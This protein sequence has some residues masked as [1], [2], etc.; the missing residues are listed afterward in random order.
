[1]EI[2]F[3]SVLKINIP[4]GWYRIAFL[5]AY[6]FSFNLNC[7]SFKCRHFN[8]HHQCSVIITNH[9]G[10]RTSDLANVQKEVRLRR[11]PDHQKDVSYLNQNSISWSWWSW[12]VG[13]G[14]PHGCHYL[15][16]TSVSSL[17]SLA[18]RELLHSEWGS[19][20]LSRV[21]PIQ[22]DVNMLSLQEITNL[23]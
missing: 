17:S 22:Q 21:N 12:R 13:R 1:M 10:H 20:Q 15:L 16:I 3:L 11:W 6:R 23:K 4:I 14:C 9:A 2:T 18:L 5:H 8:L 19:S 7:K